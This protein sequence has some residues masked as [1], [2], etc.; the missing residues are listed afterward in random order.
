MG[1]KG[2]EGAKAALGLESGTGLWNGLVVSDVNRDGQPD[3]VVGNEGFNTAWNLWGDHQPQVVADSPTPEGVVAVGEAI[4]LPG[5]L[6]PVRDRQTLASGIP[7]LPQRFA[8]HDLFSRAP[9][10]AVLGANQPQRF[11]ASERR[12]MVFLKRGPGSRGLRFRPRPRPL[13]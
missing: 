10:E 13:R 1:A 5:R 2:W 7:D 12:S 11:R 8:T 4:Q 9:A 3:L 6:S